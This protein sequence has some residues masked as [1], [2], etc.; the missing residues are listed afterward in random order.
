MSKQFI[1]ILVALVA[2]FGGI[3]FMQRNADQTPEV[4]AD[5]STHLFG[6]NPEEAEDPNVVVNLTEYGDFQCPACGSYYPIVKEVKEKYADQITFQFRHFPIVSSHP[7]AMAAHRAAEAAAN[8]GKFWEMH[9]LLYERQQ[10]WTND[11]N[12]A[13]VFRG[14][15]QELGLNME[16]YDTDVPSRETNA[17]IQADIQAGKD[18]NVQG[19]P[20]F[21]LDGKLIESPKS[22]EEFDQL[23]EDAIA[24]KTT[25]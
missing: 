6:V 21:I 5:P 13:S 19:T 8:Q 12:P 17:V 24:Q 2:L 14:Y 3:L 9:D 4:T 16:Q 18:L 15:A 10:S 25:G 1:I 23:I 22:I 20:T 11:S 7:N